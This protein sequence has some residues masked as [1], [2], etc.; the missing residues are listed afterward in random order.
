MCLLAIA[1]RIRDDWP[2]LLAANRDEFHARAAAPAERQVPG[3]IAGRDLA[4]GGTWLGATE[5]GRFA[6]VTNFRDPSEPGDRLRSRGALVSG[7]LSGAQTAADYA[8][9]VADAAA[10]YRGFNLLLGDVDSLWYVGSRA[11]A[12]RA[13]AP[14]V[15]GLSNHLLDTPWPKVTQLQ[16]RLQAALLLRDPVPP[17]FDALGDRSIAA[18]ESLPDTGIGLLRER[19]LSAAFIVAPGYGTRCSTVLALARKR[20][21]FIEQAWNPD[22]TKAALRSFEW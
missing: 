14:G 9:E 10:L 7:F 16:A 1:W 13:L 2:L 22:G 8:R 18:D 19:M 20:G 4:A 11:G 12:P 15:H 3:Y 17:L 21:R 5:N 6:V